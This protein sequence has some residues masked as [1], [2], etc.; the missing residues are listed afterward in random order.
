MST[1]KDSNLSSKGHEEVSWASRQMQVLNEIKGE[2]AS[3]K[4]LEGIKVAACMH[5]TKET[6]NLMLTL[7]SAGAKVALCASN[8]LST[9]DSVAAYLAEKGV[10]V[11]AI[12]GVSNDDFYNHLNSVLNTN[13]DITM[14]DG[15]DLVTLLHKERTE[16]PIMGSME[17][18]TTGV[19]RLRAMEKEKKLRFPA[20]AVNDSDT[21]H[22]FDNRF[23]T[24]QSSLDGVIRATDLLIAG[25]SVGIIGFGDCGKGVAERA[26][27][28][29][30]KVYVVETNPVRALEAQMQGYSVVSA[31]TLAGI[32]DL[33]ITVT[34]NKHVISKE[35]F[36]L[37]KDGIIL[38]NAGHFDVEIDLEYLSTNSDSVNS[39]RENVESYKYEGREIFVIGEGRLVNLVASTGHPA[40]VMD[41]SF[42]NQALATKWIKDNHETLE[43]IVYT[44][45]KEVDQEIAR[46][47]LHLMG[48]ELQSLSDEQKEYLTSWEFGTS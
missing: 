43:N 9:N 35:L 34:G 20:V 31:K 14:D 36:P 21:K 42:A 32:A 47:K 37:M 44:L 24:G 2:F 10:E 23:G 40:S 29:G 16:I 4:E 13:P 33:I 45:P 39:V 27:G 7:Q 11:H 22:L 8:P 17:E 1:I 28:M 26:E 25:L 19:I 3:S 15:A 38:A 6:A 12:R 48:G 5:V 46:K 41:M 30:A 18:T